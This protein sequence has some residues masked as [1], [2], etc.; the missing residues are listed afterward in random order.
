MKFHEIFNSVIY[1]FYLWLIYFYEY[2][3]IIVHEIMNN[4][5][6]FHDWFSWIQEK[7]SEIIKEKFDDLTICVHKI[8]VVKL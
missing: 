6:R 7:S 4:C 3:W 2:S 8:Y 1:E 5:S